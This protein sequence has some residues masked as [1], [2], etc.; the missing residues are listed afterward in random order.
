MLIYRTVPYGPL[1][2]VIYGLQIHNIHTHQSRNYSVCFCGFSI[3]DDITSWP[4][5]LSL[6]DIVHSFISYCW[7]ACNSSIETFQ[8]INSNFAFKRAFESEGKVTLQNLSYV[9]FK[10]NCPETSE[11]RHIYFL[12]FSELQAHLAATLIYLF[13]VMKKQKSMVMTSSICLFPNIS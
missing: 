4:L 7:P 13:Y 8:F 2:K 10:V 12:F 3:P 1:L 5:R 11:H 9:W 6:N